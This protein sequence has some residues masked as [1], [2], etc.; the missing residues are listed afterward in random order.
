MTVNGYEVSLWSDENILKS[1]LVTVVQ[2]CKY[3]ETEE[4]CT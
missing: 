4:L 3:M 1:T 2:F